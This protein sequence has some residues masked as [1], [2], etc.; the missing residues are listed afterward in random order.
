MMVAEYRKKTRGDWLELTQT[1]VQSTPT[2][3]HTE[4]EAWLSHM[5]KEVIYEWS[6]REKSIKGGGKKLIQNNRR[7]RFTGKTK[8]EAVEN[9]WE[10]IRG[11]TMKTDD[12]KWGT[13]WSN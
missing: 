8:R 4:Y 11:R 1:E 5:G 3:Y 12:G 6:H 13:L 2:H 10:G 9:L 7:Q